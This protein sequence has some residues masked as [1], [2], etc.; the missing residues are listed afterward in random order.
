MSTG[1]LQYTTI[2]DLI[3]HHRCALNLTQQQ[4]AELSSVEKSAISRIESGETKRPDFKTIQAIS[5]VLNIS[6]YELIKHYVKVDDRPDVLKGLLL[7]AVAASDK[8]A[9]QTLSLSFLES[10][11]E[12][13]YD[14]A[15][16]LY[17]T[18]MEV[19]D[20][21]GK[22]EITK[23]IINYSKSRGIQQFYAKGLMQKYF[24]ER[25]DFRNL[26]TIYRA[27]IHILEYADFLPHEEKLTLYYRAGVH[28]YSLMLFQDCI[29]L[30]KN[31]VHNDTSKSQ[32][33]SDA[34]YLLCI[35]SF[36][37]NNYEKGQ[38]FLEQY[39]KF[40]HISG[41]SEKVKIV[42]AIANGK[43]GKVDLAIV[44]LNDLMSKTSMRNST[45]VISQ[46]IELYL[47]KNHITAAEH[48]L[49]Y[50]TAFREM[51]ITSPVKQAELSKYY[52][53]KG[54]VLLAK[55][56]IDDAFDSLLYSALEYAKIKRY[57]EVFENFSIITKQL[58]K[59][60]SLVSDET[61]QKIDAVFD[62][63]KRK[64]EEG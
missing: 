49:S 13:S 63:L 35:S 2:G 51:V 27:H 1:S 54:L 41:V 3:R 14:L 17:F 9:I 30:C 52:R 29:N 11:R 64:K 26:E 40:D 45:T 46:L 7:Q 21:M 28:A 59:N 61:I 38:F 42:T 55:V 48:L 5:N 10:Q 20:E 33:K 8:K 25:D 23:A 56:N 24:I 22:L 37:I 39:A 31:V 4:L 58:L 6:F 34:L 16:K 43:I 19:Q 12:E 53:L 32:I 15:E 18:A 36:D 47:Q 50:E 44:Q 57:N 60:K 62:E